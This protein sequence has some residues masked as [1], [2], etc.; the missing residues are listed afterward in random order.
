MDMPIVQIMKTIML[1]NVLG[2]GRS[3]CSEILA[4]SNFLA[5]T[6]QGTM[7]YFSVGQL[8]ETWPD[9]QGLS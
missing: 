4:S 1:P 7:V 9:M 5:V 3:T 8:F 2:T 6:S